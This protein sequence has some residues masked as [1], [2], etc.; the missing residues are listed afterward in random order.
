MG[1]A[2]IVLAEPIASLSAQD[3]RHQTPVFLQL[4]AGAVP[5]WQNLMALSLACF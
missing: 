1:S 3:Q 2:D 5:L 4:F